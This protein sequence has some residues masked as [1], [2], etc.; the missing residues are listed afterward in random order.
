MEDMKTKKEQITKNQEI[1]KNFN[2]PTIESKLEYYKL[3]TY[4]SWKNTLS[5]AYLN[6]IE[7]IEK[8]INVIPSKIKSLIGEIKEYNKGT[9]NIFDNHENNPIKKL[10]RINTLSK[11]SLQAKNAMDMGSQ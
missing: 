4:L 11:K 2:I 8:Q 9:Q 5:F 1:R 10:R 7:T 3:K 6:N